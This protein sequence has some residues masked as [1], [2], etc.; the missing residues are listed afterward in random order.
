[1]FTIPRRWLDEKGE[2]ELLEQIFDLID[3]FADAHPM[4][5]EERKSA[6]SWMEEKRRVNLA[7]SSRQ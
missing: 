4:N 5:D 7:L 1:M 2:C 3:R 6:E